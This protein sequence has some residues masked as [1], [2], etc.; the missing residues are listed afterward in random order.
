[1][2]TPVRRAQ[3]ASLRNGATDGSYRKDNND[4]ELATDA[5]N[6]TLLEHNARFAARNV[7]RPL[8]LPQYPG[9]QS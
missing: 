5:S 4:W 9:G 6:R 7:P 1:M 3:N 2:A 8:P